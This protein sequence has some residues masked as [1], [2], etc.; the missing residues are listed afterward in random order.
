MASSLRASWFG[1]QVIALMVNDKS[2]S[3]TVTE[4]TDRYL[5]LQDAAGVETLVMVHAI[6]AIKLVP[7]AP[8]SQ[9]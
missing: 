3:G 8:A 7:S 9:T 1:R 6:M 5:V 2:I 4:A